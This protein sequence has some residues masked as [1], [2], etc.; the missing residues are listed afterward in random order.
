[1]AAKK[2]A[3]GAQTATNP[4]WF[5]AARTLYLQGGS[6]AE[7]AQAI[8]ITSQEFDSYYKSNKPF[9]EFVDMGR[10]LAAAW[11][12][13]TGRQA[14]TDKNFN[15]GLWTITMKNRFGWAEKQ[16]NRDSGDIES[17]MSPDQL[18]KKLQPLLEQ[19]LQEDGGKLQSE[20]LSLT[21]APLNVH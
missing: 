14:L 19:F 15:V 11:W 10:T 4:G 5:E 21:S 16:D 12:N 18:R 17:G 20:I 9:R 7:V 13:R 6:D 8:G 1:M 2:P 3:Q